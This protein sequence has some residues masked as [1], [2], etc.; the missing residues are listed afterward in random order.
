MISDASV[1]RFEYWA[2]KMLGR[3]SGIASTPQT[4]AKRATNAQN[5]RLLRGANTANQKR[6]SG[7]KNIERTR[8]PVE[9]VK[10]PATTAQKAELRHRPGRIR[11]RAQ[12]EKGNPGT[13]KPS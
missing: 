4:A 1:M 9:A 6:T 13:I 11:D 10:A 5:P 2:A 7:N 12:T 3:I 8:L